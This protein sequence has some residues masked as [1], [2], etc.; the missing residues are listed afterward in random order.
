MPVAGL[1]GLRSSSLSAASH[2]LLTSMGLQC[3]ESQ[4]RS[5]RRT[6]CRNQGRKAMMEGGVLERGIVEHRCKEWGKKEMGAY[7]RKWK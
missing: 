5:Q 4:S 1:L 6:A 3:F 7:I 2:H